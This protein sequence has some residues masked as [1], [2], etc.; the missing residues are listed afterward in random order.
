MAYGIDIKRGVY[1]TKHTIFEVL[2]FKVFF[3]QLIAGPIM[4]SNDLLPQ[5][6]RLN[7]D[8]SWSVDPRKLK[9][10]LWLIIL[11]VFKK[12]VIADQLLRFAAPM[13][14][15]ARAAGSDKVMPWDYDSISVWA[16]VLGSMMMLYTDFSAY[17]DMARG[18]GKMLGFELPINFKAPFMMHSISEFWKRWHLT[19]SLWIR[20]YIFIP[21]GGSRVTESRIYVNYFI[22]FLIGG[23]WHGANW[24]FVFWGGLMGFFISVEL[25]LT[26]RGYPEWPASIAGRIFR[27]SIAWIVMIFSGT[28]FFAPDI[29]W[30]WSAIARMVMWQNPSDTLKS[31]GDPAIAVYSLFAVAFFHLIEER[32]EFFRKIPGK[33]ETGLLV[34]SALILV[35]LLIGF[36]GGP[37]DFFYF[38]F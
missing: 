38:Q 4:R 16:V 28:L 19:F 31:I 26:K 27:P 20:D 23:L 29:N 18:F 15:G 11:G 3:P 5:I 22:T 33:Y 17:T 35:F 2:L 36:A 37:A 13:I 10:G 9:D 25:F 8:P 6:R 14:M 1:D 12:V 30:S 24:T 21:L 32:P 34:V 7:T